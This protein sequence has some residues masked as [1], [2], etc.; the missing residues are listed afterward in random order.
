MQSAEK[1]KAALQEMTLQ[2]YLLETCLSHKPCTTA[3]H[4]AIYV[5][6]KVVLYDRSGALQQN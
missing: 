1:W 4:Y 3:R 2:T 5:V 6:F